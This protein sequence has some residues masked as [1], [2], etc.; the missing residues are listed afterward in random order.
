VTKEARL[1]N[2]EKRT[3]SINGAWKIGQLNAKE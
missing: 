2:R 1:Y 3:T